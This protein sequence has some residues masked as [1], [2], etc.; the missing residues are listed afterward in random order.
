MPTSRSTRD[1]INTTHNKINKVPR[2]RRRLGV[3][4]RTSGAEPRRP[5]IWGLAPEDTNTRS[6]PRFPRTRSAQS[7]APQ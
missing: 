5:G 3:R 6:R 4:S 7:R 2:E 1:K